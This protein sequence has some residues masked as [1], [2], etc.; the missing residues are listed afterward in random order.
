MANGLILIIAPR[1]CE[2]LKN[3]LRLTWSCTFGQNK[4]GNVSF[5]T[6]F[7]ARKRQ[8]LSQS[9][10][11]FRLIPALRRVRFKM[12][13]GANITPSRGIFA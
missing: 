11:E 7:S 10:Q 3:T 9:S 12:A 13:A 2:L 5:M 4:E 8:A 6:S 1:R